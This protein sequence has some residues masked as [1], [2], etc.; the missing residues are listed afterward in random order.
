[1]SKTKLTNPKPWEQLLD[2]AAFKKQLTH[3][4]L[5]SYVVQQRWYGGKSSTLKY[6]E[7]S[8]FFTIAHKGDHFYGLLLEVNF[9]EAFYQHYFLPLGFVADKSAALEGLIAPIKLGDQ[10]GYLVDAL[11]LDSFRKVLFEKIIESQPVEGLG[12]ITFHA[13]EELDETQYVSSRFLGAEQSN[14]SIIFNDKHIIKFFR[15]IYS[16]TNP[17]YQISRYL[18]EQTSFDRSPTYTG[19]INLNIVKKHDI[20]LALM[21][22]LVDNDGDGWEWMLEELKVVFNTLS[23]KRID[24]KSLPDVKLFTRLKLQEVPHEIVDWTGLDLLK[25]IRTL[26]LRTAQFHVAMGGERNDLK[27][28]ADKYNGD[29]NVWLKNRLLYMFQNRLNTVENNLHKLSGEALDLAQEL[30]ERKNE[31]RNRFI[32][33]DWHHM[34]GERIRIHGDYHLGQVLV[35]GEDFYLLDFEGEPESTIRDRKVKQMPQKDLAGMFRSFHYAI[36]STIFDHG[37][38]TGI[39][40][41]DLYE[42]GELL[43]KYLIS[44]FMDTY[45]HHVHNNNLNIG[46][47]KEVNFLLQF[48]LLEKA[49]YELGYEFNSR[50]SWAIIP[51]RGIHSIMNHKQEKV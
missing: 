34:K 2:D 17:D 23:R 14:T 42:A 1:M 25:R 27:F 41:D 5:E 47:R 40:R 18:T 20:T 49:I 44:I 38:T 45:L 15:R 37:E 10:D 24:I 32:Q 16:S 11:Y 21:Q 36:Y 51:L 8:E 43:Y 39:S 30:L 22:K 28:T 12:T 35:D 9:K 29:Y 4:I 50:P 46:Y 6:L 3:D 26:A 7:I 31:I 19:S 13:G 48:C 33:F